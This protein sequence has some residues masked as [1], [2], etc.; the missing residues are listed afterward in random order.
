MYRD[1]VFESAECTFGRKGFEHAT[2]QDIA[3]EAGISLKTLYSVFPGKR[4]L[5]EEIQ[6]VRGQ[7][8][9]A[10]VAEA[11]DA[12]A[13]PLTRLSQMVAAYVDFLFA[14]R[15]WFG[16]QLHRAVSWGIRPRLEFAASYWE[17]G[18]DTVAGILR[19]GQE[20]GV[21][22]PGDAAST[23]ALVQSL[24]QTLVAQAVD[25]G[26]DNPAE[27]AEADAVAHTSAEIFLHLRRLLCPEP[28]AWQPVED[29]AASL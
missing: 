28:D 12:K 7:A 6:R 4:E 29:E 2:M 9:V 26:P 8:F 19:E 11:L 10:H 15:D 22:Y 25:R 13:T 27:P 20:D 21:F 3:G 24:L 1:L 5:Y 18:L 23:A 16:I 14:H 17:E